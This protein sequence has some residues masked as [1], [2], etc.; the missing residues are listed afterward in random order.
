VT[1]QAIDENAGT[2]TPL[3]Q[4]SKVPASYALT[5]Q[6]TWCL[7]MGAQLDRRLIRMCL[8]RKPVLPQDYD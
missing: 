5:G 6:P 8:G 1:G 4:A 2:L 7:V 3:S